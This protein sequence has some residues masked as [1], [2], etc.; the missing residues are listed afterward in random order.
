MGKDRKKIMKLIIA[1][2]RHL[3]PTVEDIQEICFYYEITPK[4]II[5]GSAQGVDAA[6]EKY[7]DHCKLPIVRFPADWKKYGKSAGPRRNRT[8]AANADALLLIWDGK[9]RGS[10]NMME[11]AKKKGIR[12]YEVL[13]KDYITLPK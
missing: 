13:A 1:G 6:G 10:K 2:S 4:E 7:A 5:S 11:E 9:S 3:N 8:M 12:I